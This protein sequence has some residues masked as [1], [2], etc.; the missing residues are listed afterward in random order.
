MTQETVAA[1]AAQAMATRTVAIGCQFVHDSPADVPAIFQVEPR[2]DQDVVIRNARWRLEPERST[3]SYADLYGNACRRLVL[4]AG[5]SLIGFDAVA[6]V[7]DAPED[8]DRDAPEL[9][10]AD[11]PEDVLVYTLPSRYCLPDV[12]GNEAWSRFGAAE[13]G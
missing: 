12:L 10:P 4:P 5:R 13:P 8:I 3:R 7:P 1:P 2:I 9:P 11:L 6:V